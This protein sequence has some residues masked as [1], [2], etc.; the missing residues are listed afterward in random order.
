MN[1]VELHKSLL[2]I[3]YT[4]FPNLVTLKLNGSIGK[5][6]LFSN[7]E[8]VFK[9]LKILILN[10][11]FTTNNGWGTIT[12]SQ[13]QLP[14]LTDLSLFESQTLTEITNKK[15]VTSFIDS[16]WSNVKNL[17]LNVYSLLP[18]DKFNFAFPKITKLV[19]N[20]SGLLIVLKV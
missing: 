7:S 13:D 4:K 5:S 2:L 6:R 20:G 12:P 10:I 18:R 11:K 14:N 1:N 17:H 16:K 3:L 8:I 15:I 9:Q 19:L